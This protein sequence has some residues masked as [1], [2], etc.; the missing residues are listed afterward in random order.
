MANL[1]KGHVWI[2]DT[3]GTISLENEIVK[4]IRWVG[5]GGGAGGAE[6]V[7]TKTAA[8]V[9]AARAAAGEISEESNVWDLHLSEGFSVPTLL[10]STKLYVYLTVGYK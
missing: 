10:A 3:V 1:K 6:I 8:V 7:D 5:T 9:W 4:T 2:I